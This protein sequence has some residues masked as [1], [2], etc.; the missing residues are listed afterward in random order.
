M[1]SNEAKIFYYNK[2]DSTIKSA[3]RSFGRNQE[4]IFSTA[5]YSCQQQS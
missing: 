2:K 1:K 3:N 4:L 5:T